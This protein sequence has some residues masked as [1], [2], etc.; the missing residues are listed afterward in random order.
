VRWPHRRKKV[1]DLRLF[2]TIA[3]R[4]TWMFHRMGRDET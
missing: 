4:A 2:T 1:P 3:G